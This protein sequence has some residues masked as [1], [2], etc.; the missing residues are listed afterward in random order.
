MPRPLVK[1]VSSYQRVLD[2]SVIFLL[3]EVIHYLFRRADFLSLPQFAD[4]LIT[5]IL[6]VTGAGFLFLG[7]AM[8]RE[9]MLVRA[10]APLTQKKTRPY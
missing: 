3:L 5:T 4:A 10:A 7:L 2:A 9:Q 6:L 8:R 1:K